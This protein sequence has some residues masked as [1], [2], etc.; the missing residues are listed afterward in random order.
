MA[1]WCIRHARGV[2]I[3][4]I[5]AS[6]TIALVGLGVGRHSSS[7]IRIPGSD[8]QIATGLISKS[9][10]TQRGDF[11]A[12]VVGAR[13]GSLTSGPAHDQAEQLFATLRTI[14]G[15]TGVI[16]PLAGEPGAALSLDHR[17]AIAVL[18][19]RQEGTAV[20]A[21]EA[22]ALIHDLDAS[23]SAD[24]DTAA[25]GWAVE[26]ALSNPPPYI[27]IVGFLAAFVVLVAVFGSLVT[28]GVALGNAL[29]ALGVSWGAI[30]LASHVL[31]I[32]YFVPQVTLTVGLGIGIDY[33][34]LTIARYRGARQHASA[35]SRDVVAALA[36]SGRTVT[37]AGLTVM[38]ASLG[39]LLMPLTMLRSIAVGVII[40]VVPTILTSNS[41]LPALVHLADDHLDRLRPPLLRDRRLVE[42]SEWWGNW[43]ARVQRR[44]GVAL[45][46]AVVI[47]GLLA[48]PMLWLRLS[49]A[50]G[51]TDNP[52]TLTN[53][54]YAMSTR[55]FGPGVTAPLDVVASFPATVTPRSRDVEW[56]KS[57]LS[58]TPDVRFVAPA[59][60]S[61][62]GHAAF[63]RVIPASSAAAPASGALIGQIR[64]EDASVLAA[65]GIEIH[66]GGQEAVQLDLAATISHSIPV[67][68][69]AVILGSFLLLLIQFRSVAIALK[70]GLMNLMSIG[71]AFGLVVAVFQWG[72]GRQLVGVHYAGPIQSFLPVLL[73]P[74]IFGLS[75]DYEVF[76]M[77]RMTDEW[78]RTNNASEAITEGIATTGRV[79][80]SGAAIMVALFAAMA[81][82]P[83]RTVEMFGIG[84]ATA[85]LLDATVIRSLAVPA[86][87]TLLGRW[88][89]WLPTWLNRRLPAIRHV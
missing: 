41:L 89:W 25:M 75:M 84:L 17:T 44:P 51:S 23:R 34:L 21:S 16:D 40:G 79:V 48:A 29:L 1:A 88:N 55:A 74:V 70:A 82:S 35:G 65:R 3:G 72:W 18:H 8:S 45:G 27:E 33:G 20:P 64:T 7:Q 73:F 6:A 12:I 24:L 52:G 14:P 26:D 67:T 46:V 43:S 50:D 60:V 86:A 62:D 81:L 66:V 31:P 15:V 11:E 49:A 83:N 87:M 57:T 58:N 77:S 78:E 4:W 13:T 80:T 10:P 2:V 56:V 30:A 63:I 85:V 5:I 53:R 22:R 32:P 47:V 37:F 42:R 54:A 76:L 19:F 61:P 59:T 36:R 68:V 69:L 39:L 28:V 9:F 71:A 38:L